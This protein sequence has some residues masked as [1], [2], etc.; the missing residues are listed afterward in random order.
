[1]EISRRTFIKS[2]AILALASLPGYSVGN[3]P[4]L[5]NEKNTSLQPEIKLIGPSKHPFLPS[6]SLEIFKEK[7]IH[8]L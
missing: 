4:P 5:I 1:M 6:D 7:Y 2:L 3:E 8:A